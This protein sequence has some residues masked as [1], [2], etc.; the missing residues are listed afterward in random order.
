MENKNQNAKVYG[1]KILKKGAIVITYFSFVG[2]LFFMNSCQD[3]PILPNGGGDE[4]DTTW[5]SD[6][7]DNGGGNGGSEPIDSTGNGGGN[8]GE[9]PIDSADFGG[10]GGE[11]TDSI[12]I[13][14]LGG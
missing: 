4:I 10:N 14:S 2:V 3:D 13:D 6:S 1:S 9:N 12:F 8:G 7:T 5:V 11:P